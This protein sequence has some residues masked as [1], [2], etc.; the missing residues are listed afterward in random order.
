MYQPLLY[1]DYEVKP[2]FKMSFV[3]LQSM[4]TL[5]WYLLSPWK[6]FRLGR[7]PNISYQMVVF[8]FQALKK[9]YSL[10]TGTT[11]NSG[12][13]SLNWRLCV[14]KEM[15][16]YLSQALHVWS[17]WV[18]TSMT[19]VGQVHSDG[20]LALSSLDFEPYWCFGFTLRITVNSP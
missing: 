13:N 5:H 20:A 18:R 12:E 14:W 6:V 9:V 11:T 4:Y 8:S 17:Y 19:P 16:V 15:A 7:N 2:L 3:C 1:S 10:S